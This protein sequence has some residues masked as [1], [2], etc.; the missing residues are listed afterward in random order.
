MINKVD[1]LSPS[2]PERAAGARPRL[3]LGIDE[4]A[5]FSVSA[6]PALCARQEQHQQ[7]QPGYAGFSEVKRYVRRRVWEG[8]QKLRSPRWRPRCRWPSTATAA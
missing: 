6:T 3:P 1:Q 8:P 5:L 7:Q 4:P 2:N